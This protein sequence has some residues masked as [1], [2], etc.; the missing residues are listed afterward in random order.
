MN[1]ALYI[2]ISKLDP[3]Y[4]SARFYYTGAICILVGIHQD[5]ENRLKSTYREFAHSITIKPREKLSVQQLYTLAL[6]H[7]ILTFY[8]SFTCVYSHSGREHQEEYVKKMFL[9]REGR[10][11]CKN[12]ISLVIKQRT[13]KSNQRQQIFIPFVF[14]T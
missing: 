2:P 7:I 6:K 8:T 13:T 4:N 10:R 1:G 9:V 3:L 5:M 14:S 11:V 12:G